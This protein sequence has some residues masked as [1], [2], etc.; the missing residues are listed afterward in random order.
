MKTYRFYEDCGHGWLRVPFAELVQLGI[1]GD[2]SHYSYIKPSKDGRTLHG[3]LEEDCDY[4]HFAQAM[5]KAGIQ[6]RLKSYRSQRSTIR[7][8][9]SY[10]RVLKTLSTTQGV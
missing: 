10:S 7:S 4:S 3:Y 8:Y 5:L 2:I 9:D 1:A 6:W